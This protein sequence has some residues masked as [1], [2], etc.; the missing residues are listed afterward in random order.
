MDDDEVYLSWSI[1]SAVDRVRNQSTSWNT[2]HTSAASQNP[3]AR[4]RTKR[5]A[6]L[7]K[8]IFHAQRS[9]PLIRVGGQSRRVAAGWIH[10]D[11]TTPC[12]EDSAGRWVAVTS[13]DVIAADGSA[14]CVRPHSSR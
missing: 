5:A 8:V 12:A 13:F 6:R 14:L 4:K 9:R 1:S 10:A 11:V 2:K 7:D 3:S